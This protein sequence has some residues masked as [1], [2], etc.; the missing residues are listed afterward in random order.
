MYTHKGIKINKLLLHTCNVDVLHK[1]N[2]EQNKPETKIIHT[3]QFHLYKIQKN[4]TN[5]LL[6]VRVVNWR[7]ARIV[8]G[9]GAQCGDFLGTCTILLLDLGEAT[10][11]Q[12]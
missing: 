1:H 3:V 8:I 4:N 9:K 10:M 5:L 7:E 6:K 12:C 11:T 2:I